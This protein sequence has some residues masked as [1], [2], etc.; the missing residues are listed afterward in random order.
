MRNNV[1][2]VMKAIGNG[3]ANDVIMCNNVW[4]Y[5]IINGCQQYL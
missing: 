3:M 2:H 1:W 4:Q 5:N